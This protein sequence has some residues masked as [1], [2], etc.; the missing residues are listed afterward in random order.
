MPGPTVFT[1]QYCGTCRAETDHETEPGDA[2]AACLRC[3]GRNRV[4]DEDDRVRALVAR[5]RE[6][7]LAALGR[8]R[9][10]AVPLV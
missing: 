7:D 10:G 5:V 1:E 4:R 6:E 9:T 8:L 3:G 2:L